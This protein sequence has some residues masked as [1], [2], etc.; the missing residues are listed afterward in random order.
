MNWILRLFRVAPQ[1]T[2]AL[3]QEEQRARIQK[4]RAD[5]ELAAI[6]LSER[7][8]RYERMKAI[9]GVGGLV[10]AAAAVLGLF[11]SASQ[12]LQSEKSA[13]RLRVEER[14]DRALSSM[15]GDNPAM[16]LAG[17]VS[18]SSFL[19]NDRDYAPQAL[20][21]L[22]NAL[23]LEDSI[24]VRNAIVSI[25]QGVDPKKFSDRELRTAL[26]SL[27]LVSRGLVHEGDLWSTRRASVFATPAHNSVESRA[28]SVATAIAG[29]LHKGART[30]DLSRVYLAGV[31]LRGLD[32]RGLKW[33]DAILAWAD[34]SRANLSAAS[35]KDSDMESTRF[36]NAKLAKADFSLSVDPLSA[37][38]RFDYVKQQMSRN[39]QHAHGAGTSDSFWINGPDFSCADLGGAS[40]ARHPLLPIFANDLGD[41]IKYHASFQRANLVGTKFVSIRGFGVVPVGQPYDN[42]PF[43]TG[44]SGA[45]WGSSDQYATTDFMLQED[46]PLKGGQ[47]LFSSALQAFGYEFS[48]SNWRAAKFDR[49]VRQA[50][51]SLAVYHSDDLRPCSDT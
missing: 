35:F 28:L 14:L 49:S 17:V 22:T 13:R 5:T 33:D 19:Q 20:Q 42:Q 9:A 3:E 41:P 1:A 27:V 7:H 4:L 2:S 29:L 43:P 12:W 6:Q 50:L 39:K 36:V 24:T 8:Q 47:E 31:D 15:G 16:R 11:L 25:I 48:G 45:S 34:F 18:V 38:R 26:E 30:P 40:F 21:A 44:A 51:E 37:K 10:T 46:A 32:L 23:A